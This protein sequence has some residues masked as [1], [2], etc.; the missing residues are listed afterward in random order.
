[1]LDL[2]AAG[3]NDASR[4]YSC[5]RAPLGRRRGRGAGLRRAGGDR[6]AVRRGAV[7]LGVGL[8][9]VRAHDVQVELEAL[10]AVVDRVEDPPDAVDVL[11]LLAEQ[12]ARRRDLAA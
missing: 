4:S 10:V 5:V 2:P 7:A 9:V 1:M 3:V 8:V 6:I 12:R 11:E